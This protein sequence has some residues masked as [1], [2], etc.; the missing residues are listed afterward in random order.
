MFGMP[1]GCSYNEE[2]NRISDPRRLSADPQ[3][4]FETGLLQPDCTHKLKFAQEWVQG[5]QGGNRRPP[6]DRPAGQVKAWFMLIPVE[7]GSWAKADTY[8]YGTKKTC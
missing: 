3:F 5:R 2:G 8:L 6:R 4:W 1:A 7:P